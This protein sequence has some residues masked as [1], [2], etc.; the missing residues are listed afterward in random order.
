MR[1]S[2]HLLAAYPDSA[3]GA[4]A[5]GGGLGGAGWLACIV[6]VLTLAVPRQPSRGGQKVLQLCVQYGRM[7]S[8]GIRLHRP[9]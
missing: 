7:P 6:V 2:L 9:E 1:V 5:L 4:A 3:P 8:P